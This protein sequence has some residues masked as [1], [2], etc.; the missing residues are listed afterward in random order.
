LNLATENA[1]D[2]PKP[3]RTLLPL[4]ILLFLVSYGLMTLLVVEQ[5]RIIQT[6]RTLIGQLFGDSVELSSMKGKAVQK[7]NAAAQAQ[8]QANAHSQAQT[9][10]SQGT[11]RDNAKS[12]RNTK[13][14]RRPVPQ[15]PPRDTSET[16]DERR[17]LI[18]I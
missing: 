9:P 14:F 18:S 1:I 11:P 16:A 5:D 10:S 8:A 7:H 15:K 3:K 12:D 6:Q 4:L 2:E 13:K 17:T